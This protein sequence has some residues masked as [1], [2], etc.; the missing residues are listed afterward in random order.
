MDKEWYIRLTH[1][2]FW[3]MHFLYP[4]AIVSY[5]IWALRAKSW[6][7]F[8]AA[9]PGIETGGMIGE[10]K[11]EINKLIPP[12]YRPKNA[13]IA[14][15]E[16][17][18][19]VKMRLLVANLSY[20]LIAKPV[21]GARGLMVEKVEDFDSLMAHIT[22]FSVDFI[23]E[24]FIDYPV[25]AAVLYWKNPVS[26]ES[27]IQSITLK[28]FLS[29]VGNNTDT[30]K[31]LLKKNFRGILQIDRLMREKPELMA[32]I[33]ANGEDI[34]VEPIG[35]H[36]RGTMFLN[37]NDLINEEMVTAFDKIQANLKGCY[38]FR[39]DLKVPSVSDLQKGQN[40]KILE[41][42]G[43]GSEPAH[44]YDPNYPLWKSWRDT[45]LMWAKMY[46]VSEANNF[47]G[48]PYQSLKE[49]KTFM[50]RQDD[51]VDAGKN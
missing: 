3:P 15:G 42:N 14:V 23:V 29:V 11:E 10:S 6:L 43:V 13:L 51:F 20:P 40:I 12:Q 31:D 46:E 22:R 50:K 28:S 21:V 33:P 44:I 32:H 37:G 34:L 8:T 7:F 4:L 26:L 39:L 30:V 48:I 45:W 24:E 2:E 41:I 9:N 36:C 38:F 1:K 17:P 19:I 5:P 35:N 16:K 18:N 27:G 25:E 49:F 47:L